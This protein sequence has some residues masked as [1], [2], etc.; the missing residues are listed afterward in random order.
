MQPDATSASSGVAKGGDSQVQDLKMI[1]IEHLAG[2]VTDASRSTSV[3]PRAA[4]R[5]V[6][7]GEW[8]DQPAC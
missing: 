5:L 2:R 7:P 3:P 4:W 8:V 1:N 6:Q